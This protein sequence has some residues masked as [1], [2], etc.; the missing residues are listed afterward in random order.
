VGRLNYA[1]YKVD[2]PGRE[3]RPL[4]DTA[5]VA[6][7]LRNTDQAWA[8]WRRDQQDYY[9]EGAL[10]WLEADMKIRTLSG[11]RKSLDDFAALFF[12]ATSSGK[13]GDTA[14]GVFPY[15]FADVVETLN[16]VSPYDWASFW[17]ERLN[18]LSLKPPTTGLV[19]AGYNYV[20]SDVMSEEEAS[21]ITSSHMS[22]MLH[23]LG[24]FV[25]PDGTLQDVW[26]HSA[27]YIAG[28]GPGD[29][30][31]SVNGVTYT[32][33]TLAKAVRDAKTSGQPTILKVLRDDE[34]HTFKLKYFGGEKY[35]VLQRNGNP[36]TLTAGILVPRAPVH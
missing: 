27:A 6:P 30:L 31:T 20:Q 16:A 24:F 23:S 12:G 14:P 33:E 7:V 34:S 17:T 21:F 22:D 26:M 32:P 28:L 2:Q 18:T 5:D 19:Q 8:N 35:A 11:G 15:E 29:K 13:S 4:Q 10:L 1:L 36:D 25:L 3:W 9:R